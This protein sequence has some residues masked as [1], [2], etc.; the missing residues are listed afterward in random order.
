VYSSNLRW[1][2]IYR[3]YTWA[4]RWA[5]KHIGS[6]YSNTDDLA[7]TV[8]TRDAWRAVETQFLGNRETRSLYLDVEF[9]GFSQGDLSITDNC[10]RLQRM[11]SD[12]G[13]LGEVV[14]N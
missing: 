11:A 9:H 7:N 1:V 10:K 5:S 3:T 12:L 13:A 6:I 4:S 14:S 2:G 8:S